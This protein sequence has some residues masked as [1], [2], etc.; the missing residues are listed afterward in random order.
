MVLPSLSGRPFHA[1]SNAMFS[2]AIRHRL[3]PEKR[4]QVSSL[5]ELPASWLSDRFEELKWLNCKIFLQRETE[6]VWYDTVGMQE[7]GIM[8]IRLEQTWGMGHAC[9]T[10]ASKGKKCAQ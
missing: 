5:F 9:L 4:E 7:E 6:G 1:S 2:R 3:S 10:D 8:T